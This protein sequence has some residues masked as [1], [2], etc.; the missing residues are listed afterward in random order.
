VNPAR[1]FDPGARAGTLALR[2]I[3]ILICTVF[4]WTGLRCWFFQDDFAWLSL[5]L[6]VDSL[7]ALLDALFLPKAQGTIRPW[8]ERAFF[9]A[10]FKLFGL[11]ALPFRIVAFLT[12]ALNLWLVGSLAQ[13]LTGSRV[14]AFVAP[15]LWGLNA[16]LAFPLTWTS[17]YNQL[18]CAAFLLGAFLLFLRYIETGER[19]YYWWQCGVFFL[20]FGALEINLVYPGLAFGYAMLRDRRYLLSTIP[21]W[22]VSAAYALVHNLVS[23]KQATGTYAVIVDSSL[24]STFLRYWT[25]AF[26]WPDSLVPWLISAVLFGFL[27]TRLL[28]REWTALF[29]YLWFAVTI[30]PVLPLKN[31]F[32]TYYLTVPAIG[33]AIAGAHGVATAW[34][35]GIVS[36]FGSL[37]LIGVYL[38]GSVPIAREVLRFNHDRSKEVRD[39]IWSVTRAR[40]LHPGKTILLLGVSNTVFWSGIFHNPFPL[41]GVEDVWLAPGSD[42]QIAPQ[43]E[44]G[45][46]SDFILP[47]IATIHALRRG[48]AVVYDATS[49]PIRNVTNAYRL[50]AESRWKPEYSLRLKAGYSHFSEQFGSGWHEPEGRFRW[51]ARR[52][53]VWLATPRQPNAHLWIVGYCPAE[54]VKLGPLHLNI[55]VNGL[56]LPALELSQPDSQFTYDQPLPL[57]LDR[58]ERLEIV[59][60]LDRTIPATTTGRELGLAFGTIAIK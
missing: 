8:S 2:V 41:A 29:P 53:I 21:L 49:Y 44:H 34:K 48:E 20:G 39:L 51:M 13:K 32:T 42:D 31:H 14:A 16:A 59:F 5:A 35:R 1:V 27:L 37:L 6:D 46:L 9:M 60:E 50:S 25:N 19:R 12:Q 18:M 15:L 54:Q 47:P 57:S 36:G 58:S 56:P 4:F 17:S 45:D 10:L 22:F 3:P 40:E 28:D 7:R 23:P 26:A 52:A 43:P 33:L 24:P 11:D 55:T 38:F 30:A